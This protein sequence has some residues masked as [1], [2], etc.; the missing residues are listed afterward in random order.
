MSPFSADTFDAF[1]SYEYLL[2]ASIHTIGVATAVNVAAV[3]N[4]HQM[5]ILAFCLT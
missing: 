2:I 1:L 3:N 5:M 4:P